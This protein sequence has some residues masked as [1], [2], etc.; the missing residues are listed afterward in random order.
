MPRTP[1]K[2]LFK[3]SLWNQ[4]VFGIC[5]YKTHKTSYERFLVERVR[6]GEGETHSFPRRGLPL[7]KIL[8][9][10]TKKGMQN[11]KE[12]MSKHRFRRLIIRRLFVLLLLLVQAAFIVLSIIYY[13][14]L[15]YVASFLEVLA[16]LTA[17]HLLTRDIPSAFKTSLVFLIL[18]FPLFGGIL[19]WI[20]HF[21]TSTIGL[22]KRLHDIEKRT[23]EAF[24]GYGT[25]DSS[26]VEKEERYV[27]SAKLMHYLSDAAGFPICKNTSV[28]YYKDGIPFQASLLNEL[29][30]AKRYIFLE[31][32]IIGEGEFWD[33]ILE[34]LTERAQAGVDVR[35]IYDDLG[36]FVTLPNGYTKK[37]RARGIRCEVFN[38][39][40]PFLTSVQNNR[41]HRKI[42][43]IDGEVAFT[44]GINI[45]DEYINARERFGHWKDTAVM[46]RGDGAWSLTVMFLQM[47]SYL[48][49]TNEDFSAYLP[50]TRHKASADEGMV[51]PY[52]DSPMDKEY[53]GEYTYLHL[54]NN[55]HRYLYITTP[56]LAVD[57]SMIS[58]LRVAAK[59]GVDVRII[60]P[61]V[62]DKR[63]VQFTGRSF[64]PDL[65]A[66]GVRIYEYTPGFIHAKSVVSDDLVATVGTVNFDFRSLYLHF[67][68]GVCLYRSNVIPAIK[69]DFLQTLSACREILPADCRSNPVKSLLQRICR[70]FA[71]LM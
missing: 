48:T 34:I 52:T 66:A 29:R 20:F 53:V 30:A 43:V 62:P 16:L 25:R 63:F 60:T 19:Y 10:P 42:A 55:A 1:P 41:D 37:L 39:F 13:S 56:Y 36:S 5:S 65:L 7:S 23:A 28:E 47:W 15:R 59:S 71:P 24:D 64:Y 14:H 21:Q 58:A 2:E 45:A 22:R 8:L 67:E 44:G 17:L 12:R 54:I 50:T 27:E 49:A 40:R 3:K 57:D 61:A 9:A 26:R 35:V 4:T 32:F 11:M 6:F 18:L 33:S 51:Q 31:Y 38:P 68:C 69:E 70:L 46:L